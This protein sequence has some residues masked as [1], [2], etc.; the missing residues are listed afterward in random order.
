MSRELY[1]LGETPP[2]GE[3]PR[4][5]HAGVIRRERYGPPEQS[6]QVETVDV[7]P[8]GRGQV[9]IWVMAAGINYN[10][11]WAGLGTPADVIADR[12]RAGDPLDFHIAGSE[13]AGVVWAVGE[14]VKQLKVGDHVIVGGVAWDESAPDI[15]LGT[16]PTASRS[17]RAWGYESNHGSFAQFTVADEY[18]CHKKP[19]H[20][21]WEEAGCFLGGGSTSYRMLMG[22]HPHTVRPGDPV[23]VW[24][25]AGGLGSM[26]I[27][28]VKYFGGIPVAVVSDDD[29]F[30]YCKR[31]GARGVINRNDF[32]H[33]GRLPDSSDTVAYREWLS[34]VR[35]FGR[36]F[37]DALGERK[38]P[39][40]VLE[41]PGRATL[42]TSVYVC[43][44][45]G[46]VVTC[47]GTSGYNGDID[48]RFL[49]MFQKRL[50]GSHAANV[51][52][53]AAIIEL[54]AAGHIDPCLSL[55]L[56]FTEI[57]RAHQ[58]VYEN[59]QPPGNVAVLVN[60]PEPGLSGM[61]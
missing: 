56:P 43:D 40:I 25:G 49:W 3:V 51:R 46:M 26:A 11:V 14:G 32:D 39:A 15:R 42:P 16:D 38:D 8:V 44:R 47:A 55:A 13:G 19:P 53:T 21:T 27:Q 33:W 61:R 57:G 1:A 18:Q 52:Q 50:Q 10:G 23:L 30:D 31:L 36:A 17:Q 59:K 60:A 5:M 34:G 29:K 48:L 12:Q 20:L 9:L 54:V 58:M 24:G 22:W 28:I 2:L 6:I 41:H 4:R 35:S 7:P 37:W 45:A